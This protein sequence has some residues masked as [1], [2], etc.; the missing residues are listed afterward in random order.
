V[1]GVSGVLLVA[2]SL[3]LAGYFVWHAWTCTE[4]TRV[5]VD[6][7]ASTVAVRTHSA[8]RVAP[9]AHGVMSALMAAMFLGVT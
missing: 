2:L 1:H 7:P 9:V 6:G 4:R 3:V 5:P 8:A